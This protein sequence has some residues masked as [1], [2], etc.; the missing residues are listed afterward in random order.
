MT[1]ATD[2]DD[3]D[4]LRDRL[5]EASFETY[6]DAFYEELFAESVGRKWVILDDA[7]RVLIA[8]TASGSAVA[9]WTL[10]NAVGF[11]EVWIVL[12][13]LAAGLAIVSP[14]LGVPGKVK[15]WTLTRGEFLALRLDLETLRQ[16]MKMEPA[17]DIEAIREQYLVLRKRYGEAAAKEVGDWISRRKLRRQVQRELNGR[18]IDQVDSN[19]T[20]E[21]T[22]AR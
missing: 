20:T 12:A 8:L 15:S 21:V 5:W 7:S 18:L 11:R 4:R 22:N 3:P 6:Y 1:P 2:Q 14:T 9:G 13:G 10:W 17:F 16:R 19:S